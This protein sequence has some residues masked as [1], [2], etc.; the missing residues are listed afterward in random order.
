MTPPTTEDLTC[1]QVPRRLL[2]EVRVGTADVGENC[3]GVVET[4]KW[5]T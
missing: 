5:A 1:G 2:G 4:A 3:V